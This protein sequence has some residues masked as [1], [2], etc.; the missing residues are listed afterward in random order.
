MDSTLIM[1]SFL[2]SATLSG[3]LALSACPKLELLRTCTTLSRGFYA[4]SSERERV[5]AQIDALVESGSGLQDPT[6]GLAGS[7]T[8]AADNDAAAPSDVPLEGLWALVYTNAFD[9]VSLASTPFTALRGIYF[10]IDRRGTSSNIIDFAPRLEANLPSSI[11]LGSTLR[12]RVK[13]KSK[14]R[15]STRVGLS[16]VGVS[17]EPQSLLGF[18]IRFAPPIGV[19]FPSLPSLGFGADSRED[20]GDNSPGFYDIMYLDE[21]LLILSQNEPGGVFIST[22]VKDS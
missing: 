4:T 15:S 8:A 7:N 10:E 12:A 14:A 13:T 3:S 16:F 5:N 1:L 19:D 22:K 20:N 2:I 9:V 21:N 11:N 6:M 17:L 18:D